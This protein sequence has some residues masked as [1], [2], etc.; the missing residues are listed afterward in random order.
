MKALV[1]TLG[2]RGD[3]QPFVALAQGL[4]EAGHQ[5]L[6]CGPHGFEGF[7]RERGVD[8]A[9][10]DDGPM[11]QL[12][13]AAQAGEVIQGGARARIR[14]VRQMPAMFERV[15]GDC[16]QVASGAGSDADLVVH[17]GQVLAGQHIA[18]AMGVP[19]VLATPLPMYV[20]TR[21][22]P[23]AGQALPGWLPRWSN[24]ATYAGVHLPALMFRRVIDRWRQHMLGLPRRRGR[25]DPRRRP[26][27]GPAPVLHAFSPAAVPPPSDWPPGAKVTGY[28]FPGHAGTLP[29]EVEEF[30]DAGEAPVF[31]GFGSMSGLDPRAVTEIVI[32]AAARAGRR[33]VLAPGW[34]GLDGEVARAAAARLGV[35]LCIVHDVDHRALFPQMA[36]IVHHGGAG[37]T[38][39][40]LA[41][42]RAQVVCPFVADQ[43]FWGQVVH[44]RG[45]GPAPLPQKRMTAENLA[46]RIQQ[47]LEPRRQGEA[48]RLGAQV[49]SEDG[50][51][52]A[53]AAVTRAA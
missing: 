33:L 35:D 38:G 28:W 46:Q 31:A 15:L 2:T 48:A 14:Q 47:A 53:V 10:V 5:A 42:G 3:V 51:A 8:F 32:E 49:R 17:N 19:A 34:G 41:A 16:W 1:M 7:V 4:V 29:L 21:E 39:T 11:R 12:D 50:V 20:P 30:L 25:H 40:A 26:D 22:F 6:V 18:E 45:A 52:E 27:G 13:S 23:W 44:A 9:G 37:T 24:R 43:P 36:A